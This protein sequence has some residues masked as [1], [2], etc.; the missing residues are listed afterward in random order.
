MKIVIDAMGGDNAPVA[1]VEGAIA[2][3]TEWADTQIVLVGDEA[4]LEPL[5]SKSGAKPA[6][7]TVRHASEVIGSDDEPVKAVRRKKDASMVVA[8][9]MLKEGEADAM[10][11]AGNT[12]ALMTAGLL[13][14]GRMEGIERPAL[15]PMIPTIDDVGVLALDLGANMDAKPEHLAQYGLMGSLYRQKVQGIAS[16]RVGLLNVGTEP[17]KGNELTKHAYPLLEQLPIRF[18]GNVEARDVLTGACDVLVCDGF[19]GNILLKSLEG[20]AGAIFALLK[21]QFSSSLKSKLAAAVL[22]PE[23]RG[24]KRKLDYTEHGGAP[25]LGLSRLVVKSHGSADGNAIKNAV[26]QARI[27]VQNQLVESISKEISGK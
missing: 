3:A 18:V 27:A 26:R 14:V 19:A 8:G 15:A 1:T 7:L 23:L 2:A 22:M 17:G 12:G 16:P 10:I 20:T 25:L 11:S 21:E 5:L 4:K 6:N 24:L 9:R 13:V